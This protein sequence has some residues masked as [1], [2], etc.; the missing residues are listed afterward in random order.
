[1]FIVRSSP[2]NCVVHIRL[3][4]TQSVT[5]GELPEDTNCEALANLCLTLLSGLTFRVSDGTAA[6]L[7]FRS[8][9]LFVNALGFTPRRSKASPRV[10]RPSGPRHEKK[11]IAPKA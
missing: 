2:T 3:R 6:G 8:I 4:L 7:L 11:L 10:A 9:Q 5:E 1:M